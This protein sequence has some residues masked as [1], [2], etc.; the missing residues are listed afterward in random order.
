[1]KEDLLTLTTEQINE[2]SINIDNQSTYD[3]L[4]IMNDEDKKVGEAVQHCLHDIARAVDQIHQAIKNGGRLIY[5]GAGTSGRLGIL[6]AAECPPTFGTPPE[7][8]QALMAGGPQAILK[9]VE[10]AE[11]SKE[12]AV[13]DLK[14]KQLK[15]SDIVVGITASGRTPYVIGAIEYAKE[16]GAPT[17][18]IACNTSSKVGQLA[19]IAIEVEVGPEVIMGST[20]LKAATAQKLVLNMLSSATMIKLGKIYQ[21]LMI[22]LAPT[23]VKLIDRARRIVSNVTGVSY[24][25]AQEVLDLTNQEVKTAIVMIEGNVSAEVAKHSIKQADGLVRK[26]IELASRMGTGD[27]R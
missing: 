25:K 9:A 24:E 6:D 11:D 3:M 10:G 22:D 13:Q 8:V 20:R 5:V 2:Q 12:Q 23:N 15:A 16:L 1:M 21:N 26:A 18:A 14:D 27:T 17:V 4:R 7:M 19:D